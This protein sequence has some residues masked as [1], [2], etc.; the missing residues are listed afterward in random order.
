[1]TPLLDGSAQGIAAAV[2]GGFA[3]AVEVTEAALGRIEARDDAYGAFTDIVARRALAKAAA[4]DAAR[5]RGERVGPLAGAPFAV[6]N[7]FDVKGLATRAGSKINRDLPPAAADAT[8]VAKLE[9]AGAVLVGALN[10]GEYAYDFTGENAHDGPSRN[11]HDLA[12][13][14]GGS[15]GGSGAAVAGGLVPIALGSDTNGSIRVPS[16]FC[17]T[18]GLKPTYGRL[19]RARTFPFVA[20]LDHLGPFARSVT[21]LALA[22]DAM[23]GR[24]SDDPAQADVAP[25]PSALTLHDGIGDLRIA[26]LG[27]WF[28]RSGDP[29]AFEAVD[30]VAAALNATRTVELAG[31]AK[32]RAAAYLITMA[33]GAALHLGRLRTRAQDFDPDVRDRLIA[34]AML[35]GAWVAQA[36]KFRRIFHT[37]ALDLFRDVDILLAPATPVRAPK[38]GQRTFTLDGEEL[39]LR[40]NIG[41][42]TQPISF[43]GLPVV[44]VPVWTAGE[45]LPIGVQVIA[46]PWRE[47]LA[48]RVARALERDG[49]VSAPVAHVP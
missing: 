46:P 17:G 18:F 30:R 8:L 19:S 35:P 37:Q 40:P 25:M 39:L 22:Y 23:L 44:A 49:V 11:P 42:F 6:K 15:S 5:A 1:M 12:H 2:E 31:A 26:K 24:D 27:G 41:L 32:A 3:S 14:A 9:A 47:D 7:L 48:L 36:Q 45:R 43:I 4:I 29:C 21:D 10:M 16:S 34:G 28:A 20:S 13:M 33:E 38:L